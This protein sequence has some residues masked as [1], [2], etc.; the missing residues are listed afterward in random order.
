MLILGGGQL[1]AWKKKEAPGFRELYAFDPKTETVKRLAD[2]PTAFYSTH[3]AHDTKHDLFFAVAVFNKKE[4]PSGMFAYDPNKNAWRSVKTAN[5]IPPHNNWFG[6][7]KLCYDSHND[8]LIGMVNEKFFAFRYVGKDATKT[9]ID[10]GSGGQENRTLL[11]NCSTNRSPREWT[12]GLRPQKHFSRTERN[13]SLSRF[14]LRR[15]L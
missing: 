8:C 13:S 4:Q 3:L 7:M 2:A 10:K 15:S 1:D 6:W 11:C 14:S 12:Y 5:P 9:F